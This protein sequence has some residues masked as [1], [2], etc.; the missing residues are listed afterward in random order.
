MDG[1]VLHPLT[2]DVDLAPV[3]QRFQEL[4][5]REGALLTFENI[6][7]VLWHCMILA[8][9]AAAMIAKPALCA[10]VRHKASLPCAKQPRP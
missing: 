4:R 6:F 8:V 9:L 7:G 3:A 5:S 2:V 10:Y 1:H